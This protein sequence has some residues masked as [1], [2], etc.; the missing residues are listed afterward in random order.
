MKDVG[1]VFLILLSAYGFIGSVICPFLY[2]DSNAIMYRD[3]VLLIMEAGF[4]IVTGIGVI[5]IRRLV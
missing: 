1:Y 4:V 2:F 5:L 3:P